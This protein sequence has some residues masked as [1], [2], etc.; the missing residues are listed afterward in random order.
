MLMEKALANV[1][2]E[3]WINAKKSIVE[4]ILLH[5]MSTTSPLIIRVDPHQDSET[6]PEFDEDDLNETVNEES[7]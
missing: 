2:V 4:W 6:E 7:N 3:E 5:K 1:P